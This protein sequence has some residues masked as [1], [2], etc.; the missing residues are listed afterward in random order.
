[1]LQREVRAGSE[2]DGHVHRKSKP[3]FCV[4]D[5]AQDLGAIVGI[6]KELYAGIIYSNRPATSSHG[7]GK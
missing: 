1:M 6:Y 7:R 4:P 3:V 5:K 2:L